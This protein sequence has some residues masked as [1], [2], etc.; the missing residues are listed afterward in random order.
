MSVPEVSKISLGI[1]SKNFQ[2]SAIVS[3]ENSAPRHPLTVAMRILV[4]RC[5]PPHVTTGAQVSK[6]VEELPREAPASTDDWEEYV[7]NP[8]GCCVCFLRFWCCCRY[9]SCLCR[10]STWLTN[11]FV[12]DCSLLSNHCCKNLLGSFF[13]IFRGRRAAVVNVA[14]ERLT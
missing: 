13:T 4:N 7:R 9:C 12:H 5:V 11:L 8:R 14:V 10:S 3:H 2:G 1:F 6:P